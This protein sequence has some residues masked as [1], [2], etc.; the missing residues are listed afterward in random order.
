MHSS[1]SRD[2]QPMAF[3][4]NLYTIKSGW[5]PFYI[6]YTVL[7]GHKLSFQKNIVFLP[8][9]INFVIAN[10]AQADEMPHNSGFSLFVKVPV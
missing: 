8:L 2:F 4:I 6:Q 7:R 5:G 3:P 1:I 10:G 9:K